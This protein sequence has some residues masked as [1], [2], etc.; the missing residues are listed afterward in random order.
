M[1]IIW[2]NLVE[3]KSSMLH[4]KI[5]PQNFLGS[6]EEDFQEFLPYLDMAATLFN[7]MELF[8]QI[9]NTLSTEGSCEIWWKLLKQFQRRNLKITQFYT[10]I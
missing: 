8:E 5:Q 2:T 10:C 9:G 1:I 4:T 6:G 7:C 3:L